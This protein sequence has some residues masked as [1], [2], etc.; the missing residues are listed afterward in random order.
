[1]F[2]GRGDHGG[3]IRILVEASGAPEIGIRKS[4]RG[5]HVLLQGGGRIFDD[6]LKKHHRGCTPR[7]TEGMNLRQI[8]SDKSICATSP[9]Y[10]GFGPYGNY[11]DPKTPH[12]A[13]TRQNRV[14][15]WSVRVR[16]CTPARCCTDIT[17]QHPCRWDEMPWACPDAPDRVFP[18][19][20]RFRCKTRGAA[21]KVIRVISHPTPGR[22]PASLEATWDRY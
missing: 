8:G 13:P 20:L 4:G 3:T 7:A 22:P 19:N 21:A 18:K 9:A 12:S 11:F 2:P 1:M 14:I 5:G 6:F 17:P 15:I 10:P 16:S